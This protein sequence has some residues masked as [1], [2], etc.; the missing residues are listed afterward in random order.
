MT[1]AEAMDAIAL[2]LADVDVDPVPRVRE[3][4]RTYR[5]ALPRPITREAV[6]AMKPGARLAEHP[7]PGSGDEVTVVRLET[8]NYLVRYEVSRQPVHTGSRAWRART[9]TGVMHALGFSRDG[10]IAFR[11]AEKLTTEE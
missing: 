3:V 5:D 10:L 4:V 7:V 8:G 1:A 11:V 2:I 6:A 9:V